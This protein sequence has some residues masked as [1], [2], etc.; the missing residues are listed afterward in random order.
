MSKFPAQDV[1]GKHML[2]LEPRNT[3]TVKD[4]FFDAS[5][6]MFPCLLQEA[7][8]RISGTKIRCLC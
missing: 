8:L 5:G 4:S 7:P 6:V 3:V 1:D 2:N